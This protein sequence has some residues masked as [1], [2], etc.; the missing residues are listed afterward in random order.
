MPK[1]QIKINEILLGGK[2]STKFEVRI[3]MSF[4]NWVQY[5][6]IPVAICL[7]CLLNIEPFIFIWSVRYF[8][9]V[10]FK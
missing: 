8:N 1:M 2:N 6:R 9:T 7:N 3:N 4:A 5:R 10:Y